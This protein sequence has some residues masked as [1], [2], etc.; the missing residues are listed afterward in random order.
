VRF[1]GTIQVTLEVQPKPEGDVEIEARMLLDD[2]ASQVEELAGVL[3]ASAGF[4][5]W[6]NE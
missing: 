2:I 4:D 3:D 6:S 1:T 5:V